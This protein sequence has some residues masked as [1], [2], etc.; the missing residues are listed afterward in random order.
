[1][2]KSAMEQTNA[3]DISYATSCTERISSSPLKGCHFSFEIRPI[4]RAWRADDNELEQESI[5]RA[6]IQMNAARRKGCTLTS[7]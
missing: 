7:D 5:V 4:F 1:M 2:N 3:N 6:L